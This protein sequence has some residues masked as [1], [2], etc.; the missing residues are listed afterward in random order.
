MK[1]YL[2]WWAIIYRALACVNLYSVFN[3][4]VFYKVF[5]VS[6]LEMEK[7]KLKEVM[8]LVKETANDRGKIWW[9]DPFIIM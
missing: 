1:H 7:L 8:L 4:P 2:R 5:I 6:I 9:I 3:V